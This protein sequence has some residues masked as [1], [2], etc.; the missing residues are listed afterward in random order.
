MKP[1][2]PLP[3][4][5]IDGQVFKVKNKGCDR[6]VAVFGEPMEEMVSQ[7]CTNAAYAVHAANLYPELVVAL[8]LAQEL[9]TTARQYFPKSM[10]NGDKFRLETTCAA[11]GT[12]LAKC[13]EE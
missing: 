12:A 4:S 2:T 8:E 5:V 7:D 6:I 13:G 11:I 1:G 3:W 10:H 9:T